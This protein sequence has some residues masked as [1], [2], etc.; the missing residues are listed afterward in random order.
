MERETAKIIPFKPR[1]SVRGETQSA[2]NDRQPFSF[3]AAVDFG[4]GWYH[5]NA[6]R[7]DTPRERASVVRLLRS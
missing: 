1:G 2:A 3:Y 7:E 5:E 6:M 4:A